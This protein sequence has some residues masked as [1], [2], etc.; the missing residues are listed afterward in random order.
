MFRVG[1]NVVCINDSNTELVRAGSVYTIV[2]VYKEF[3]ELAG[4]MPNGHPLPG[5]NASRFRP[6]VE[7][8][9]DIS[10]FKAMLTP[11][12]EDSHV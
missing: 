12:R 7:R 8:K 1:M 6:I 4:I 9:T 2:R 11:A 3:L 5:M 10:L